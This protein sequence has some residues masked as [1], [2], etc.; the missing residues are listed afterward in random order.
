MASQR[1][2]ES[3][4]ISDTAKAEGGPDKGSLSAQMQSQVGK[5]R[6][7]EQAANLVGEKMQNAPEAVTSDVSWKPLEELL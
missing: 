7:Y 6:N 3:Q 5:Q 2:P 4:V 1:T